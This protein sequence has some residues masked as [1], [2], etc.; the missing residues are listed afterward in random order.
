MLRIIQNPVFRLLRHMICAPLNSQLWIYL[1]VLRSLERTVQEMTPSGATETIATARIP[2][3]SGCTPFDEF[4][5][6]NF[7]D[8]LRVTRSSH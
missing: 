4:D 6:D 3:I 1:A 7:L 5:S 2:D 8:A